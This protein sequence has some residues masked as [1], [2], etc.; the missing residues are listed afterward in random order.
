MKSHFW[1]QCRSYL[2][3]RYFLTLQAGFDQSGEQYE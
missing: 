3:G 2:F 1:I